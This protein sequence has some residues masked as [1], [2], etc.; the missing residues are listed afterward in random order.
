[1]QMED[2]TLVTPL[3]WSQEIYVPSRNSQWYLKGYETFTSTLFERFCITSEVIVDIGAHIG[4]FTILAARTNP[5]ARVISIEASPENFKTLNRNLVINELEVEVF[6]NVFSDHTGIT[7]FSITEASDNCAVG[8]H[9]N[10]PTV[11][12][13]DVENV[14]YEQLNIDNNKRILIKIDIE[15]FEYTATLGLESLIKECQEITVIV[16]YNPSA[17][18]RRIESPLALFDLLIQL[19]FRLFAISDEAGTWTELNANNYKNDSLV[20]QMG[21]V[22]IMCIKSYRTRTVSGVVHSSGLA[23]GERGYLELAEALIASRY[24]VHTI[25]PSPDYGLGKELS[26]IGSSV[27]YV[28]DL[29]WWVNVGNQKTQ[30]IYDALFWENYVSFA[31]TSSLKSVNSDLIISSSLVIPQGAISAAILAKPHIWWLQEFGD[32]DQGMKLIMPPQDMGKLMNDL[33]DLITCVSG[34]VKKHFFTSESKNVVVSY[35]QPD[36]TPTDYSKEEREF[37]IGVVGTISPG[38]GQ[39]DVIQALSILKSKDIPGRLFL[40][41]NLGEFGSE[42]KLTL[43]SKILDFG[44]TDQVHFLGFES[45]Q[46]K[47][48]S[49]IDL[50]VVTSRHEAFGRTPM[51]ASKFGLPVVYTNSAGLG[52]HMRPGITGIPYSPG[53]AFGLAEALSTLITNPE[54]RSKL[55]KSSREYFTALSVQDPLAKRLQNIFSEVNYVDKNLKLIN[56]IK[57]AARNKKIKSKLRFLMKLHRKISSLLGE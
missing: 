39:E 25:L 24:M 16:E 21:Y 28:N 27:T 9:Q 20:N 56:A 19:G 4:Y 7:E 2:L 52:E 36:P 30:D 11:Q 18:K 47:M 26:A 8:G 17:L 49:E 5:T 43:E 13:I 6:N 12:T 44:L 10:S 32:L 40:Y 53:D 14:T 51:E 45:D 15:G 41:G 31:V 54:L 42:Y 57:I 55:V 1:M 33:S 29:N 34:A 48:Y 50:L 38:K 23:G 37:T 22:N 35:H 3:G 46:S